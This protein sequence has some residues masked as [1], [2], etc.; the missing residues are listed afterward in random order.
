ME[1]VPRGADGSGLAEVAAIMG[2]DSDRIT[3]HTRLVNQT[4][5]LIMIVPPTSHW[6]G[7]RLWT[8]RVPH[9]SPAGAA[10]HLAPGEIEFLQIQITQSLT[11]SAT[12]DPGPTFLTKSTKEAKH[13]ALKRLLKTL[14]DASLRTWIK[15]A[16]EK[17]ADLQP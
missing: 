8:Y 6:S 1:T 4:L 11:S 2:V 17:N 16:L 5:F 3:A 9:D 10:F 14:P 12:P 7:W 15:T 13:Q